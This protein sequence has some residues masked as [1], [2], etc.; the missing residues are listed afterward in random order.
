MEDNGIGRPSTYSSTIKKLKAHKYIE[1]KKGVLIATETGIR[2]AT[3]LNKYF[4]K[5]IDVNYTASMEDDLD[6]VEVG[7]ISEL[8]LL[9]DF[10]YPFIKDA[11]EAYGKMYI[12]KDEE[13]G[14]NCPKCGAPLVYK[15][16]KFG[17]FIGCSNF[18]KCKYTET[19]EKPI[20]YTGKNC[21]KCGK[22]LIYKYNKKHNK[23]IGC[24]DFPNCLYSEN[25]ENK[26][27]YNRK[28]YF[29]YKNNN[30]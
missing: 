14:R 22:P 23:F 21:P 6:K 24:S 11:D 20:E 30:S 13:V 17:T 19:E 18:P 2:A 3:V 5:F 1:T 8:K 28:K 27:F 16:S 25:I 7:S 4:P 9:N 12:E 10:Y 26:K 29:K 15:E